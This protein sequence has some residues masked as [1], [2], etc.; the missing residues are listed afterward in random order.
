MLSGH[1]G[2]RGQVTSATSPEEALLSRQEVLQLFRTPGSAAS[3]LAS[4]LKTAQQK[5]SPAIE[6]IDSE[7]VRRLGACQT[8]PCDSLRAAAARL[9]HDSRTGLQMDSAN[10][11]TLSMQCYN[12][13]LSEP[14][15]K[16]EAVT[17]SW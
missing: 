17:L 8:V 10:L 6:G 15:T 5:I 16:E 4:L 14:L 2:W 9:S 1:G 11:T 12:I 13:A 7:T 3:A